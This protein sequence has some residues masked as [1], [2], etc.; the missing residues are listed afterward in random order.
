MIGRTIDPGLG[1]SNTLRLTVNEIDPSLHDCKVVARSA[2]VMK[3][4]NRSELGS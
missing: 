1:L 4:S 2:C 3:P